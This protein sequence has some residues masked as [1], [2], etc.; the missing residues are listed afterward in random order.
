SSVV[1]PAAVTSGEVSLLSKSDTINAPMVVTF[2]SSP[3][4]ESPAFVKVGD[5]VRTGQTLCTSEAMKTMTEVDAEIDC[6]ILA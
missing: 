4:P 3:S 1:A 2:Y 5:T 6:K